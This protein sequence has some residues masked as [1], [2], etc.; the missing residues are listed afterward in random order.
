[1]Q[2]EPI[3]PPTQQ[4]KITLKCVKEGRKLRIKFHSFTDE[5]GR[6]FTNVYNNSY[7]CRF[8]KDIREVGAFYEVGPNDI[9]LFN[10]G[11]IAPYYVIRTHNI[12][13]ISP[14]GGQ[15]MFSEPTP[16]GWPQ[17]QPQQVDLS[18][19]RVFEE[20]ECVCCMSER[21]TVIFLPCAHQCTCE[22][23]YGGLK[24]AARRLPTCPICRREIKSTITATQV[25]SAKAYQGEDVD[26]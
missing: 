6:V 15:S 3:A 26:V 11:R 20:S 9:D 7:N 13:V 2:V 22:D 19:L 21:S 23:C 8:P 18:Q 5:T 17:Q 10:N 25:L 14:S 16:S 1:M 24:K 12:K 4:A